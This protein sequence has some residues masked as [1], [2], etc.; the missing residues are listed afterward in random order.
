[1]GSAMNSKVTSANL[2]CSKTSYGVNNS[3]D[4]SRAPL[5]ESEECVDAASNISENNSLE[6]I[7]NN[8]ASE[9]N[10]HSEK[11]DILKSS[12]DDKDKSSNHGN[13]SQDV[14]SDTDNSSNNIQE[15]NQNFDEITEDLRAISAALKSTLPTD[16]NSQTSN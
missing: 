2:E 15:P 9:S 7:L 4:S 12:N 1:M 10:V 5:T 8:K 16:E 14:K 6:E 13:T 11:C 3:Q